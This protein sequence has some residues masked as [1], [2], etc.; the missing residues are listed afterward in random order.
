M[1]QTVI[2]L[3]DFPGCDA[4]ER[5]TCGTGKAQPTAWMIFEAPWLSYERFCFCPLHRKLIEQKHNE[6]ADAVRYPVEFA[7]E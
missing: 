6:N 4:I 3:C 5:I 1:G 2:L 7:V